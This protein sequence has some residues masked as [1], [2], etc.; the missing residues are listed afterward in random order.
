MEKACPQAVPVIHL[1]S[2]TSTFNLAGVP[3]LRRRPC[4]RPEPKLPERSPS[5]RQEPWSGCAREQ[6]TAPPPAERPSL[7]QSTS[8]PRD[9][10]G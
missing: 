7:E 4:G 8:V 2:L 9:L 10:K 1:G 6:S 5:M 3:D